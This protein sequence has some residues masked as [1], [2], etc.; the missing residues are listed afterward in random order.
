MSLSGSDVAA[1]YCPWRS[2]LAIMLSYTLVVGCFA[3]QLSGLS[4]STAHGYVLP[5]D[6]NTVVHCFKL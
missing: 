1:L 3:L 5:M 4:G 6:V 2:K